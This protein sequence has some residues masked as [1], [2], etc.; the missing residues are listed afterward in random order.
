LQGI[1]PYIS[2]KGT[3]K[4][5]QPFR[6]RPRKHRFEF[7]R[8]D[9]AKAIKKF[10]DKHKGEAVYI[11]DIRNALK[12]RIAKDGCDGDELFK[13]GCDE[14]LWDKIVVLDSKGKKLTLVE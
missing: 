3:Q 4:T 1:S 6:L 11:S 14:L 10:L 8:F 13:M 7:N 9:Y 2:G 5:S 12:K